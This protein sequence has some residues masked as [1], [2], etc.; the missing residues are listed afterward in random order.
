MSRLVYVKLNYISYSLPQTA[1]LDTE[2]SGT[3]I[4]RPKS[5]KLAIFSIFFS[6]SNIAVKLFTL[7]EKF[8]LLEFSPIK[9]HR[10]F[11]ATIF[12]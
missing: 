12:N 7:D 2:E 8:S 5:D 10:N 6:F 11:A 3:E 4:F 1:C 9:S